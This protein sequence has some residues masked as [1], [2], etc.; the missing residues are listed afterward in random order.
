MKASKITKIA[1]A[2]LAGFVVASVAA[3]KVN[4]GPVLSQVAGF[5]GAFAG[6]MLGR[7]RKNTV[8]SPSAPGEPH[9]A[10]KTVPPGIS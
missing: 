2:T 6:T 1:G 10:L 3:D 4:L 7:R 5:A 8:V 9:D